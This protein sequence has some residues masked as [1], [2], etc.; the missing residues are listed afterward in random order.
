[1]GARYEDLIRDLREIVKKIEADET[2]LEES[3]VLYERGAVLVK[4]CEEVLSAAEL[5][6]TSL[7]RD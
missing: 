4:Q 1:M 2:G 6:V 7:G 3:I 5:K